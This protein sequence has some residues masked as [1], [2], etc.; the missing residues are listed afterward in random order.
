[1]WFDSFDFFHTVKFFFHFVTADNARFW[2]SLTYFLNH[3]T[4]HDHFVSFFLNLCKYCTNNV[5]KDACLVRFPNYVVWSIWVYTFDSSYAIV[6]FNFSQ[7]CFLLVK[8]IHDRDNFAHLIIDLMIC[9]CHKVYFM[10]Y[11][12]FY[13]HFDFNN[14][15]DPLHQ[16]IDNADC[17]D[18]HHAYNLNLF[19][20]HLIHQNGNSHV[21]QYLEQHSCWLMHQQVLQFP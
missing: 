14:L 8:K 12:S 20:K 13:F 3:H 7:Y 21:L 1:M 6:F 18:Q 10:N 19:H 9:L 16:V 4:V 2:R 15:F 11:D 17:T 5:V